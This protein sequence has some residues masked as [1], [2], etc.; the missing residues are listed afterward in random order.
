MN[1]Q[2]RKKIITVDG[3]IAPK[4]AM[5]LVFSHQPNC[6]RGDFSGYNANQVHRRFIRGER[7]LRPGLQLIP[8][9]AQKVVQISEIAY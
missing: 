3:S 8:R 1:R 5:I 4:S 7:L 2:S 6:P 9:V